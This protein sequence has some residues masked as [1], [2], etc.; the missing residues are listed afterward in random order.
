M[1]HSISRAV[2]VV[3][4]ASTLV[5]SPAIAQSTS[6]QDWNARMTV[7]HRILDD[8]IE[9]TLRQSMARFNT[10]VDQSYPEA[11]SAERAAMIEAMGHR[12]PAVIEQ[13]Q[14]TAA[15]MAVQRFTLA[16]LND[17]GMVAETLWIA[18]PSALGDEV[19]RLADGWV[20]VSLSTPVKLSLS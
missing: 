17:P 15:Q 4:F 9:T 3:I 13:I 12:L 5:A 8:N 20:P 11:T 6:D 19:T 1:P 2:A 18:L 16:E 10:M 14:N 7:A